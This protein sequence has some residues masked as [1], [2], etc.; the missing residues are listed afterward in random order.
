[1]LKPITRRVSNSAITTTV[2]ICNPTGSRKRPSSAR[3]LATMPRL[4]M[5]RIPARARASAKVRLNPMF[6][7]VPLVTSTDTARENSTET[8]A[9][10]K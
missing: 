2:N 1:M 3:T 10:R 8:M 7:M 9:A 4:L 6:K 5:E